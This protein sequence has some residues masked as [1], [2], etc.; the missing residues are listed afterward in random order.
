MNRISRKWDLYTYGWNLWKIKIPCFQCLPSYI[1][2]HRYVAMENPPC[3]LYEVL[4]HENHH[5]HRIFH[6]FPLPCLI[7]KRYVKHIQTRWIPRQN[8]SLL[9]TNP[10]CDDALA[11]IGVLICTLLLPCICWSWKGKPAVCKSFSKWNNNCNNRC[12]CCFLNLPEWL[13]HLPDFIPQNKH[14]TYT[15]LSQPYPHCISWYLISIASQWISSNPHDIPR[16]FLVCLTI[17]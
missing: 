14:Q 2:G 3:M 9:L 12:P 8:P 15:I 6:D 7:T 10:F 4:S 16:L 5:L 13:L 1:L 11:S 17:S